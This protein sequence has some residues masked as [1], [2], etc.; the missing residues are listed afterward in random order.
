MGEQRRNG[1][2]GGGEGIAAGVGVGRQA[3]AG[4]RQR[5]RVGPRL[6]GA[7]RRETLPVKK[8]RNQSINGLIFSSKFQN[9]IPFSMTVAPPRNPIR[10]FD[11]EREICLLWDKGFFF[12]VFFYLN[13]RVESAQFGAGVARHPFQDD[14]HQRRAHLFPQTSN[15]VKKN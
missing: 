13:A 1:L 2:A 9:P 15:S 3:S 12:W 8:K 7:R 6:Q 5:R 4:A 10:R 14:G 11:S